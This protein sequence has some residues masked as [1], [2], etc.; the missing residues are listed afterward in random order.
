MFRNRIIQVIFRMERT[1][2]GYSTL[3]VVEGSAS[4]HHVADDSESSLF[5]RRRTTNGST[6]K[7]E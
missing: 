7:I 6:S 3:T 4:F 1:D 2:G 5:R